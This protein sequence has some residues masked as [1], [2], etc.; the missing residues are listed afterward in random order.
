LAGTLFQGSY[1]AGLDVNAD[2]YGDVLVRAWYDRTGNGFYCGRYFLFLGSEA[3]DTTPALV[4]DASDFEG[5][6][7]REGFCLLPDVNGDGYDDW[8]MYYVWDDLRYDGY[9]VFF[10]SEHPDANYDVELQGNGGWLEWD[11]QIAGGDFNGDGI[12]DIVT[13][14]NGGF[15][16][17]GEVHI[18]LG[19]GWWAR[20]DRAEII[21]CGD[22]DYG[23]EYRR[24]GA[25][26]GGVGDYNGDG[27]DDFVVAA[28]D[29]SLGCDRIV[30]FAGN[31]DWRLDVNDKDILKEVDL[32]LDVSPN[33]FND[34]AR[35]R[36][37]LAKPG[38]IRLSIYNTQ[39]RLIEPLL[40]S[41]QKAGI[42]NIDIPADRLATG[43]YLAVLT[44]DIAGSRK[45]KC[46]KMLKIQ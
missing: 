9:Y 24:M 18:H 17:G 1:S 36:Y 20:Q 39:G 40:N 6:H 3:P 22:R 29:P 32:S 13:G 4:F 44:C 27:V 38:A 8:G 37:V 2:G 5:R 41:Y 16:D 25:L 34:S 45:T 15:I 26:V 33:P 11:G 43:L 28:D 12:G 46:L 10:G 30:V 23:E 7:Q 31:R 14:L 42:H 21:M 35:L 19:S